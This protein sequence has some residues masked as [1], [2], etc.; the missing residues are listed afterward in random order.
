MAYDIATANVEFDNWSETYDR[1]PLQR[2][3][4]Q[5]SHQTLLNEISDADSKLLDIGCGTGQFAVTAL[6][7]FPR[8][9]VWGLDLSAKMLEHCRGRLDAYAA[10]LQ[11]ARGDSERLPFPDDSF[12]IVTCSHSFHHYPRQATV[13]GEMFRVL[14]P[15]GKLLI[16]DGRRDG[17]WGW[18][19]YDVFVTLA[20]GGV[21][22][23][24]AS[25]LRRLFRNAGFHELRQIKRGWLVPYLLTIGVAN[26]KPSFVR[27][28]AAQAA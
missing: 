28:P 18:M 26:K 9:R 3:L 27:L 8:L 7:R 17:W 5:P 20:E 11:V 21:H 19:I 16:L 22:H 10:R 4:F 24:S 2:L 15:G 14:K 23:C 1:S 12:D 6:N 13:V 25:R